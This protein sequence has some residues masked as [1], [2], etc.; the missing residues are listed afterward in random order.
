MSDKGLASPIREMPRM[1]RWQRQVSRR[2]LAAGV[3]VLASAVTMVAYARPHDPRDF[4][5]PFFK[6]PCPPAH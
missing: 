2:A 3:I 4:D 1:G 6:L 5:A